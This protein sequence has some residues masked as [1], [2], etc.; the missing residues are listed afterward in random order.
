MRSQVSL[1]QKLIRQLEVEMKGES[2]VQQLWELSGV[3]SVWSISSAMFCPDGDILQAKDHST[4]RDPKAR[5][6][7][8]NSGVPE[9]S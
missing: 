3:S 5:G 8:F 1:P 6:R 2:P 7:R 4:S 9:S